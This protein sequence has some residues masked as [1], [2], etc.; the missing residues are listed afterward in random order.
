MNYKHNK[1]RKFLIG[2]NKLLGNV[3]NLTRNI[4]KAPD[5]LV[6]LKKR[7]PAKSQLFFYLNFCEIPLV[8]WNK[9]Y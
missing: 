5:K 1:Q 4:L 9:I 8:F 2:K 7:G 6:E 3:I